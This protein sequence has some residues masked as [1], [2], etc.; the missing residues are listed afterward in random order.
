MILKNIK[1]E[2]C[3][4]CGNKVIVAER[5][6]LQRHGGK[7][8]YDEYRNFKCGY[9][10]RY[11]AFLNEIDVIKYRRCP[12]DPI[13]IKER[14]EK[15]K[16]IDILFKAL[17]KNGYKFKIEEGTPYSFLEYKYRFDVNIKEEEKNNE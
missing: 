10:L 14:K 11:S 8:L 6:E 5:R 15:K 2:K 3:P 7:D 1:T 4:F 13:E 16:I 12:Q 9:K 17:D